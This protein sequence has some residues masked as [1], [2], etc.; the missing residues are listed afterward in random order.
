MP[1][2]RQGR[3]VGENSVGHRGPG[4]GLNQEF[5]ISCSLDPTLAIDHV[6][7]RKSVCGAD[8]KVTH[9]LLDTIIG[10]RAGDLKSIRTVV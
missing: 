1:G 2:R 4:V 10:T 6:V 8:H 7:Q 9:N 5:T 3:G